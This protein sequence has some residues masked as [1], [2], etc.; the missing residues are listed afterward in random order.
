MPKEN[1]LLIEE[2]LNAK[3]GEIVKSE[4]LLKDEEDA[5]NLRRTLEIAIEKGEKLFVCPYCG[6][7]LKIRAIDSRHQRMHFAH[8]HDSDECPIKTNTDYTK[9]EILMIKYHGCKESHRHKEMKNM[10]LE[11]MTIDPSFSGTKLET[12]IRDFSQRTTW[13]R[14]DV[15]TMYKGKKLV[16][17][18]Q[19]STTFLSVIVQR[20]LFYSG[21]DIPLIWI[22]DSFDPSDAR[23]S[24][25]DI[26]Y[27][28]NSNALVFD[29]DCLKTVKDKQRLYLR[30][31]YKRWE[32]HDKE[33][34]FRWENEKVD[35][36]S[37]TITCDKAYFYDSDRERRTIMFQLEKESLWDYLYEHR[38]Q[39][40]NFLEMNSILTKIN[41]FGMPKVDQ[42][43]NI[44]L[45]LLIIVM[46]SIKNGDVFGYRHEKIIS[47][48]CI[49]FESHPEYAWLLIEFIEHGSFEYRFKEEGSII[50]FFEKREN[51][52]DR[53]IIKEHNLDAYLHFLFP[54]EL[55]I[56]LS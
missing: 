14:P 40:I 12:E 1:D 36:D 46:Y 16:F 53:A 41:E 54:R 19:L 20:S 27:S 39:R 4:S 26:F 31:Y 50:K 56:G 29:Y 33:L 15:Q 25:R 28:N 10:L 24:E 51:L 2:V 6:Q 8:L 52:K 23:F 11:A 43:C 5:F 13:R 9:E 30:V 45:Q 7:N 44:I 35:F 49:V 17:E 18:I 37:L 22:F 34:T 55:P 42:K 48:V 21:N 47:I 38:R 3:T 32:K